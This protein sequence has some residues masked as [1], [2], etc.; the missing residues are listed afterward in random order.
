MSEYTMYHNPRCSKSR[1]TLAL[2]QERGV[3]PDIILYLEDKPSADEIEKLL[4]KLGIGAAQLV[5]RNEDEYKQAGLNKESTEKELIAAM[6]V[7]PK[8]IE[9]PVVVRGQRAVLGR[10][11]ENVLDLLD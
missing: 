5:R 11:P 7:S 4:S 10:P 6:A 2:L 3:E 8:L 1:N 9:R